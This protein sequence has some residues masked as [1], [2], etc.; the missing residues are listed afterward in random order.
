MIPIDSVPDGI[1]VNSAARLLYYTNVAR[2]EIGVV[3][4]K[5]FYH[6]IIINQTLDNPRA[7]VVSNSDGFV[8]TSDHLH[9]NTMH[10]QVVLAFQSNLLD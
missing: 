2:Q 7:I 3:H 6:K 8:S 5:Y 10:E 4:L 9:N 1:A